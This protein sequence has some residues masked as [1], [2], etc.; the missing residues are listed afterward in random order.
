MRFEKTLGVQKMN[1]HVCVSLPVCKTSQ[2]GIKLIGIVQLRACCRVRSRGSHANARCARF[3]DETHWEGFIDSR[4]HFE[5]H[6]NSH[7]AQKSREN[8]R[9]RA[10]ETQPLSVCENTDCLQQPNNNCTELTSCTS[11]TKINLAEKPTRCIF[12]IMFSTLTYTRY[13]MV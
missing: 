5:V 6:V 8:W 13:T 3:R 11:M 4:S 10:L 7:C 2:Y 9:S 12:E 1:L